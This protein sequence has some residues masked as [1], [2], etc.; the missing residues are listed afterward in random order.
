MPAVA[1]VRPEPSAED[2][3]AHT[4]AGSTLSDWFRLHRLYVVVLL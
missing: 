1:P 4:T 3:D 2:V